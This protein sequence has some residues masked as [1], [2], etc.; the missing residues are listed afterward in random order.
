MEGYFNEP[1]DDLQ[2]DERSVLSTSLRLLWGLQGTGRGQMNHAQRKL[3]DISTYSL[4]RNQITD[5]SGTRAKK[6][7]TKLEPSFPSQH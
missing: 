5:F 4:A 7:H 3:M 6:C 2:K 1:L